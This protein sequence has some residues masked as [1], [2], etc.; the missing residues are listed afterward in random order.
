[1]FTRIE[2]PIIEVPPGMEPSKRAFTDIH[3]NGSLLTFCRAI[4]L[5]AFI[6]KF[7]FYQVPSHRHLPIHE[8][9]HCKF[10]VSVGKYKN[11]FG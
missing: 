11:H 7:A 1:M 8:E 4:A 2:K 5:S 3:R 9:S 6:G 10:S